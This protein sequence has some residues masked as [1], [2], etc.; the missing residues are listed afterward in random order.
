MRYSTSRDEVYD[1]PT[2]SSAPADASSVTTVVQLPSFT[3]RSFVAVVAPRNSMHEYEIV[4]LD[5][6]VFSPVIRL[7]DASIGHGES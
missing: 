4:R 3:R 7:F 1:T 6:D 2:A 5:D